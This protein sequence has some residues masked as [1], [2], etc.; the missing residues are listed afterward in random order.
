MSHSRAYVKTLW[1]YPD[2]YYMYAGQ[3]AQLSEPV[4][5]QRT[6]IVLHWQGYAP[7]D[8]VKDYQHNF[9]F[10]PNTFH[11]GRGLGMLLMA[12]SRLVTKYV[13]VAD[14]HITGH[15]NNIASDTISGVSIDNRYQAL[16]EVL[17]F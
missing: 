12:D 11:G 17:G 1:S 3:T 2:G 6:G 4:S 14:D 10:V 8:S 13:Y 15:A 9:V 5:A 16:T 7:G